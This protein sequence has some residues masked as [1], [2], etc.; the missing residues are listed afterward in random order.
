LLQATDRI[1]ADKAG[2]AQPATECG[3]KF[4]V[5]LER[6]SMKKANQRHAGLPRLCEQSSWSQRRCTRRAA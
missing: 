3:D 5:W 4:G 1:S 6:A 2:F